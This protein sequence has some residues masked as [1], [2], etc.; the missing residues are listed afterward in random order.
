[1]IT[2]HYRHRVRYRECD[3]MGIVYHVHFLDHFEVARTELLRSRGLTYKAI[4]D[5]GILLKVVEINI[6][7]HSPAYYDDELDIVTMV[8]KRPSARLVLLN[9]TRRVDQPDLLVAG[10]TVLCFV[11]RERGRPTRAPQTF[12]NTLFR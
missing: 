11:N 4:E 1:M 10:R 5:S 3:R 12:I 2:H 7:Y 8:E 6:R 9:E